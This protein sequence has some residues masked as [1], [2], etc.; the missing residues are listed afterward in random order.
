MY[1][2]QIVAYVLGQSQQGAQ[3]A[4]SHTGA[5][6]GEATAFDAFFR[7][8]GILRVEFLETLLEIAPLL[9][10]SIVRPRPRTSPRQQPELTS[11]LTSERPPTQQHRPARVAGARLRGPEPKADDGTS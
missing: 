7:A 6:A 9:T 4:V 11:G 3:L 5:M 8:H 1:T 2:R 10:G